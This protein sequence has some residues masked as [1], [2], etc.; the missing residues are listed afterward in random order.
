MVNKIVSGNGND[1]ILNCSFE[2]VTQNDGYS[3]KAIHMIEVERLLL[4][5]IY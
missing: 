4:H 5:N 3:G 1:V 2:L